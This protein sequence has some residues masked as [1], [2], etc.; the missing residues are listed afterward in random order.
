MILVFPRPALYKWLRGWA[1]QKGAKIT[2]PS[3]HLPHVK[4][5]RE[6]L[7]SAWEGTDYQD[8]KYGGKYFL[9]KLL[10]SAVIFCAS[11]CVRHT[12]TKWCFFEIRGLPLELFHHLAIVIK[13]C[14]DTGFHTPCEFANTT[15]LSIYSVTLPSEYRAFPSKRRLGIGINKRLFSSAYKNTKW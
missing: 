7:P 8:G 15:P 12:A 10:P 14:S 2:L 11:T 6:N 3:H 5:W 13:S 9:Y 1:V 4:K